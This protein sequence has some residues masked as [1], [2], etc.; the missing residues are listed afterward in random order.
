[1]TLYLVRL[2]WRFQVIFIIQLLVVRNAIQVIIQLPAS[3]VQIAADLFEN[4][5]KAQ[6][7]IQRKA[8]NLDFTY[9]PTI[10]PRP[11]SG[12]A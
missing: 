10:V 4:K 5:K 2:K 11:C 12:C 6:T 9:H 3:T 1:L 8:I 7:R